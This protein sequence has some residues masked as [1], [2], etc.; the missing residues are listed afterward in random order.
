MGPGGG[1]APSVHYTKRQ[2]HERGIGSIVNPATMMTGRQTS[3]PAS[4]A[5]WV[6]LKS[7]RGVGNGMLPAKR[8][9]MPTGFVHPGGAGWYRNQQAQVA[10]LPAPEMAPRGRNVYFPS[11]PHNPAP[12]APQESVTDPVTLFTQHCHDYTR[13]VL[14]RDAFVSTYGAALTPDE[15]AAM[16]QL[17]AYSDRRRIRMSAA[18]AAAPATDLVGGAVGTPSPPPPPPP[19]A[20]APPPAAPVAPPPP[21]AAAPAPTPAPAPAAAQEEKESDSESE[22]EPP[23]DSLFP[24][25]TAAPLAVAAA[26]AVGGDPPA[27]EAAPPPTSAPEPAA[28]A[29]PT[30]PPPANYPSTEAPIVGAGMAGGS[31]STGTAGAK[32][33]RAIT[34]AQQA[35]IDRVKKYAAEKK[36]GYFQANTEMPKDYA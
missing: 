34:S 3:F 35:R 19:A 8:R 20:F 15:L 27:P 21:A 31:S 6:P 24:F 16:H 32:R 28:L 17:R 12:T 18:A 11:I 30:L 36:I 33:K 9:E 10:T 7:Q 5:Q 13:G 22:S 29:T 14:D 4:N 25:I 2:T 23:L 26:A 1:L